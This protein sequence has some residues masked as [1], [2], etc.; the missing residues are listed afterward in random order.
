MSKK[1]Y[2]VTQYAIEG[3]KNRAMADRVYTLN[4]QPTNNRVSSVVCILL[5]NIIF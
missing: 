4:K 1:V 5:R 2:Q 3:K